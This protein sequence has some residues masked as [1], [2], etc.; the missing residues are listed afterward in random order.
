MAEHNAEQWIK[1]CGKEAR[2]TITPSAD[3]LQIG[4]QFG[5]EKADLSNPTMIQGLAL[6]GCEA[7]RKAIREHLDVKSEEVS[8]WENQPAKNH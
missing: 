8:R 3:G 1:D 4:L 5:E 7:I 2:I 6:V